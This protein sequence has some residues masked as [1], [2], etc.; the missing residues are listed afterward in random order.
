MSITDELREWARVGSPTHGCV[1]DFNRIIAIADRIDTAHETELQQHVRSIL[2]REERMIEICLDT[3]E[4]PE[5]K[6]YRVTCGTTTGVYCA[7]VLERFE[8]EER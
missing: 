2:R 7:E 1:D 3:E 8:V 5:C 4:K 6:G